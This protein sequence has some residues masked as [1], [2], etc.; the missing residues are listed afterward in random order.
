MLI[1]DVDELTDAL[2]N[3][4]LRQASALEI[5]ERTKKEETKLLK[6][7]RVGHPYQGYLPIRHWRYLRDEHGIV[8][9]VTK[10][11]KTLV[12]IRNSRTQKY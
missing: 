2:N 12:T 7:G 4:H 5:L 10:A 1:Q 8:G 3:I 11:T 6:S 9:Q